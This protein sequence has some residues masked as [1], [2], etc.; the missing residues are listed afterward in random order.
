MHKEIGDRIN[1]LRTAKNMT[2]KD[3]S[4]KV[5]L[6]PSFLS[7]AERGLTSITIN[8]LKKIAAALDVDMSF[9]FDVN[10]PNKPLIRRS[11]NQE[12]LRIDESKFIYFDLGNNLE[13]RTFDPMIATILPG[14][15]GEQDI[16]LGHPG[17]EFIYVLEGVFTIVLDG[18]EH[19]MYPG[20]SIHFSSKTPHDWM[21]RTGSLVKILIVSS[22]SL[23]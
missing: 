11:Y 17:E 7:Q 13:N 16:P 3:L 10:K 22:P 21:N 5:E 8:T 23:F 9:F 6:S 12:V 18:V 4:E 19:E 20:D 1:E 15:T 2:L 14:K